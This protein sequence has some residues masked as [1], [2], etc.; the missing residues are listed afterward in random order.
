M[1]TDAA[2]HQIDRRS[3]RRFPTSRNGDSIMRKGSKI[4][5]AVGAA[6]SLGRAAAELSAQPSGM[7][8]GGYGMG[9]G[10]MG[11]GMMG[12][13]GMGPGAGMGYGMGPGAGMGYGMHGYGMGF[14]GYPGTAE[15]RL[16]GV[17]AGV[18][19]T[20]QEEA[21]GRALLNS[22]EGGG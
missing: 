18:G 22:G 21:R 8:W 1:G 4:A 5:L 16:G 11:A 6:L 15:E 9:P 12:G 2:A 19:V 17:K 13:Y 10:M 14:G 20:A 7:G 3:S